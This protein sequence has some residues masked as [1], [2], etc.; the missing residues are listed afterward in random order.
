MSKTTK[1]VETLRT[2]EFWQVRLYNVVE[3]DFSA[4]SLTTDEHAGQ[5]KDVEGRGRGRGEERRGVVRRELT[6]E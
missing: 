1:P 5:E 3:I 6:L 2:W 4:F